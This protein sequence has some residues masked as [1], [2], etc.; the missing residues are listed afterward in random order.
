MAFDPTQPEWEIRGGTM[1]ADGIFTENS[2]PATELHSQ[3]QDVQFRID[4]EQMGSD[5]IF[6]ARVK[7]L[8]GGRD[9]VWLSCQDDSNNNTVWFN[10]NS[11][12]KLFEGS[13]VSSASITQVSGTTDE[14]DIK[15]TFAGTLPQTILRWACGA[16]TGNQV[17]KYVGDGR[18]AFQI[19]RAQMIPG[20]GDPGYVATTDLQTYSDLAVGDGA[21][22]ASM[23]A[24]NVPRTSQL[25]FIDCLGSDGLTIADFDY[26][27]DDFSILV[28]ADWNGTT[29]AF[30]TLLSHWDGATD[31]AFLHG[32]T[33]DGKFQVTLSGNGSTN[34]KVY[35]ADKVLDVDG[36]IAMLFAWDGTDLKLWYNDVELTV[37]GGE[38]SKDTDLTLSGDI[39]NSAAVLG[40]ADNHQGK[41]YAARL[42]QKAATQVDAAAIAS[43]FGVSGLPAGGGGGPGPSPNTGD[44]VMEDGLIVIEAESIDI[45]GEDFVEETSVAGFV[46]SGYLRHTGA[47]DFSLPPAS[48][49]S[50]NF[51]VPDAGIYSI[52]IRANHD[53]A[54]A[55][56]EENDIWLDVPTAND[57]A[58]F[59]KWGHTD[60]GLQWPNLGWTFD[61]FREDPPA[62]FLDKDFD[63]DA[64]SHTL[65][66][67]G[68]SNNYKF[69]RIHIY[70][71]NRP[72][73]E[74]ETSPE[75]PQAGVGGGGNV[76]ATRAEMESF[77]T[78]EFGITNF[79]YVDNAAAGPG[80]GTLADPWPD[81]QDFADVAVG[82]QA[83]IISGGNTSNKRFYEQITPSNSGSAGNKIVYAGN[84]E[85]P[86][87]IDASEN[88]DVTWTDMGTGGGGGTRWRATYNQT[89]AD[90]PDASFQGNCTQAYPECAD[91]SHTMSHQLI[92]ND[93]QLF[94]HQNGN[95]AVGAPGA[96][97]EGE[98]YFEVGTG[99]RAT[100]QYVWCRL[101]SDV[102][103]NTVASG[104][105]DINGMRIASNKKWLFDVF[106]HEWTQGYPGGN[107]AEKADGRNHLALLNL[108]FAFGSTIRKLGPINIR[109]TNWHVE[110]CS[111]RD[112]KHY[113]FGLHGEDHLI[114]NCK[115]LRNGMGNFRVEW[116][117]ED[118]GTE[119]LMEDCQWLDGNFQECPRRWEA[120]NKI[121]DSQGFGT[122]IIRRNLFL[123][124]KGPA[125]WWDLFNGNTN[126]TTES[127][128]A[129]FCI[130]EEC[131]DMAIFFEHNSRKIKIRHCG[132]W[133]TQARSYKGTILGCAFRGQAAGD[134]FIENCAIVYNE[135]KG[136][137]FKN[138]DGRGTTNNDVITNN[139]IGFNV[140][141][142]TIE[143]QQ[144]EILGGDGYDDS[145]SCVPFGP[146]W[147]SSTIDNNVW[148]E[149]QQ[150]NYFAR[151]QNCNDFQQTNSVSTFES[152]HGGTGNVIEALA[153]NVVEDHTDR[154]AFWKTVG[155]HTSKGPQGLVHP[156][157]I[158]IQQWTIPT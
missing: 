19:L 41:V 36:K 17:Q 97:L 57:S 32:L 140:R 46:G 135:G 25:D 73:S 138:H 66:L 113:G 84:P 92:Y 10:I 99:S 119:T 2:G 15:I 52:S 142:N 34:H 120:G 60:A 137:Y 134:N 23:P 91:Y 12:T 71:K 111:F 53:S 4:N 151:D 74:D 86:C 157:D 149:R 27:R 126:T 133:N 18:N 93:K 87:I 13:N 83:C 44:F 47:D 5:A 43:E 94:V 81:I 105:N 39:H 56:D 80:S 82:G 154:K 76:P 68:R 30:R 67:G 102:N 69:D 48:T 64:G 33:T 107:F 136:I 26:D 28:V 16:A 45:T 65:E 38:L 70:V 112:S 125:L 1:L 51:F 148:F 7:F 50:V 3:T 158:A 6:K 95:N 20:T 121:T 152:W 147:S 130:M 24:S 128:I 155:S 40:V 98:C 49:I 115:G 139:V 14:W 145:P 127:F 103:P 116:L 106:D 88:F 153:S 11:G 143:V 109:G 42:Y 114:R 63:L 21:Q 85:L 8:V 129:E 117:N 110:W 118:A 37:A 124:E 9:I 100:P 29:G 55:N 122:F 144:V 72:N 31:N 77:I 59:Q 150:A 58:G 78:S 62:T 101:P 123:R 141:D 132:I 89:R 104:P 90:V 146:A 61:T 131:H 79:F 156:E 96:M 54:P 35:T 108:H 22:N 75:S